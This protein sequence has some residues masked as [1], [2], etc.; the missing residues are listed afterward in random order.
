[1]RDNYHW[2]EFTGPENNYQNDFRDDLQDEDAVADRSAAAPDRGE[3]YAGQYA[4]QE[5]MAGTRTAFSTV[6]VPRSR[7]RKM[8]RKKEKR[9]SLPG[10]IRR[11]VVF[12]LVAGVVFYGVNYTLNR[13]LGRF[14]GYYANVGRSVGQTDLLETRPSGGV[15]DALQESSSAGGTSLQA[16]SVAAVASVAMPSV[17]AITS[18][19]I[20]EIQSFFGIYH[21]YAST[22]S[23]S[24]ILV[25]ENDNELLIATNYHVIEGA[26]TLSVFFYGDEVT[27]AGSV[28]GYTNKDLDFTGAV[29]AV[30]KGSDEENDLAVISVDKSKIPTQTMDRIRIAQL[31]DSEGLVV[32]EQVVAIGNALG[33]G[34][35]VTS[36][37][38]SALN[39]TI[40]KSNGKAATLIQTDAA[41]NPGNSGGALL[42]LRG[43]VIGINSAKYA[44]SNVEG[45]G[46]A[47][48]ISTAR[49]IL[50]KL[51]ARKTRMNVAQAGSE[52]FLGVQVADIS[53]EAIWMYD[54]P[55]GAF[56]TAVTE[57]QAADLAGIMN[58]DIIV[59]LD[60]EK[61]TGKSDL[62]SRLQ[63]YEAGESIE[64]VLYRIL[65]GAYTELTLEVTLGG[66]PASAS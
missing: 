57:G 58:N 60:G 35:T 49:P 41:I 6:D 22:G 2:P 52:G 1:M 3:G 5:T 24:G 14:T 50:E 20:Q 19:S 53:D 12:G 13:Y 26:A 39:R 66:R 25:G 43:E 36:G 15:E 42:N 54:I 38:V 55:R 45:T 40:T 64:V 47:I 37:W 48:P 61:V 65:D 56:V 4:V 51:M 16:G 9:S 31:G 27:S 33:Y 21:D 30:V 32:G 44:S 29:S 46:F 28:S 62:I 11:A 59:R 34:Q 17:V 63:Y 10:T 8:Y 18:V 23:G 7:S